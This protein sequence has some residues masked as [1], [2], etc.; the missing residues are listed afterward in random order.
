MPTEQANETRASIV[1][2]CVEQDKH[3]EAVEFKNIV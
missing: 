2:Y 3:G 1:D